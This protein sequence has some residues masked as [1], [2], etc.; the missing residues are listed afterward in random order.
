MRS[1]RPTSVYFGDSP[2]ASNA[3][4]K[5]H[6]APRDGAKCIGQQWD[7]SLTTV[8]PSEFVDPAAL[9]RGSDSPTN[10]IKG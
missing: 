5:G 6:A 3:R 10:H 2:F 8:L 4:Q 1:I 7:H 9:C